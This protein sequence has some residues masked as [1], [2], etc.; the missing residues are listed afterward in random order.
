M[1]NINNNKNNTKLKAAAL[2]VL[3]FL[4]LVAV[5]IAASKFSEKLGLR[6]DMTAERL[7]ELSDETVEVLH[8]L[9]E[10]VDIKVFSAKE[11]F[12][13]LVAEVLRRYSDASDK[14][15]V[16]YIDPYVR[17]AA[18][19]EYIDKGLEIYLNTIVVE[20]GGYAESL[21]LEDMFV[22][23][24]SGQNVRELNCEQLLTSAV[25]RAEGAKSRSAVFTAGHNESVSEAL[26]NLLTVNNYAL[27]EMSLG[28][29]DIP[30]GTEL[31]V[32]AAP[33]TDFSAEEIKK[34]DEFMEDGGSL[35][36]F[37]EPS[38]VSLNNLSSFLEEW[39]IGLSHILVAEKTQYTDSN[40]L[41][42]V[43]IYSGHEI[44]SYFNANKLYLEMPQTIALNQIF[45]TR[46]NIT[47]AKLL[48][49]SDR[50]YDADTS[51]NAG[52]GGS[53]NAAN[54]DVADSAGT[55]NA[56]D[57]DGTDAISNN[58]NAANA[59]D[60]DRTDAVSN[61]VNA[62]K[63]AVENATDKA[64]DAGNAQNADAE[65]GPFTLAMAAEKT[66]GG[67]HA[68]LVV[69]GSR[70]IY[71]DTLM[72]T[73]TNGNA[74]FIAQCVAWSVKDDTL[75]SIPSKNINDAPISVTLGQIIILSVL[76]ILVLPAGL[77]IQGIIIYI[78]RRHS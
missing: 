78:R 72:N 74:R 40:P 14:L 63:V 9:D 4:L 22:L 12:T 6:V 57:D 62:A 11:D 27:S 39:G 13:P 68:R 48:Y 38:S 19:D 58:V 70:G 76:L 31:V 53:A 65:Q 17:P 73:G 44:N 36:V 18:V 37:A 66:A 32:I 42:I 45:V 10:P 23:D 56:H 64:D 7:Y 5:N 43:P 60:A 75:I 29:T 69:I 47:T 59:N 20:G 2:I 21:Q 55:A 52:A 51:V 30:G 25:L 71:S 15:N 54:A 35:I 77:M 61:N 67:K 24:E 34:L 33:S 46:G 28:L 8:S 26:K 41:S 3:S 1:R 49:S 16:E 50:S